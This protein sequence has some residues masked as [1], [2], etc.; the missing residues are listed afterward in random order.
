MLLDC[1]WPRRRGPLPR[2][3]TRSDVE[4]A[5]GGWKIT[6]A[7]FADTE[8]DPLAVR[9]NFDERFHRLRRE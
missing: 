4:A 1:F 8:P 3:A 6:D 9:L 2:G 5:F 7:V